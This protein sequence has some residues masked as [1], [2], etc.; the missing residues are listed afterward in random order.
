MIRP[1]NLVFVLCA[2]LFNDDKTFLCCNNTTAA[3][4]HLTKGLRQLFANWST[5][6]CYFYQTR[7]K[8][9]CKSEITSEN[10]EKNKN[11]ATSTA[12]I[13]VLFTVLSWSYGEGTSADTVRT[14]FHCAADTFV[15]GLLYVVVH[16]PLPL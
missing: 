2:L 10:A 5:F 7:K 15:R 12:V 13:V 11:P 3:V 9:Q 1:E 16:R 8:V 6:A 14:F 4:V